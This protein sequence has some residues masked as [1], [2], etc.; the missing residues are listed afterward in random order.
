LEGG[1]MTL[2]FFI[3]ILAI[4][5]GAFLGYL[6]A[7]FFVFSEN[8]LSSVPARLYRDMEIKANKFSWKDV[9]F[10]VCSLPENNQIAFEV[11]L[12]SE[13][14]FVLKDVR[15]NVISIV[16]NRQ[17][18]LEETLPLAWLS[19]DKK[20]FIWDTANIEEEKQGSIAL[21]KAEKSGQRRETTMLFIPEHGCT[22]DNFRE[23]FFF[24]EDGNFMPSHVTI[25]ISGNVDGHAIYPDK[26]LVY[27]V[28][29]VNNKPIIE[30]AGES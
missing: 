13:K 28:D 17:E 23:A 25:E 2:S 12:K 15:A 10:D 20:K 19:E 1:G 27:R 3:Q 11:H 18:V 21:F 7:H 30:L 24:M 26:R 14:P 22:Q 5:V 29:C 4:A 9:S 8:L 6:A 16:H